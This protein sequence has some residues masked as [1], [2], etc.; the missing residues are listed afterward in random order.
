MP[1]NGDTL[2]VKARPGL[3]DDERRDMVLEELHLALLRQSTIRPTVHVC[4]D[5]GKQIERDPEYRARFIVC[6]ACG[7]TNWIDP[8]LSLQ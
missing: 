6:I 8:E 4:G 3:T 5:C 2:F 7:A 1:E